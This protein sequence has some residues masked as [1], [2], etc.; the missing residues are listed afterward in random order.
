VELSFSKTVILAGDFELSEQFCSRLRKPGVYLP[1]IDAPCGRLFHFNKNCVFVGN[2][3]RAL[4]PK[5]L[6][7]LKVLPEVVAKIRELFPDLNPLVIEHFDENLL[8][9]HLD[10][11]RKQVSLE[12]LKQ[13]SASAFAGN[14]FAVEGESNI[15]SVIAANLAIAHGGQVL[16]IPEVSEDEIDSLKEEFRVWSNS[17]QTLEKDQCRDTVLGF[18]KNRLPA[19]FIFTRNSKI[20]AMGNDS[21]ECYKGL[22]MEF[23][24]TNKLEA[25]IKMRQIF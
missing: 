24:P 22:N 1:V 14:L 9:K 23:T 7:F 2:A 11:N 8:G 15:S 20:P 10:L 3:I 25:A 6:L 18:M 4:R 17:N 12:D 5:T 16:S 21:R 13:S 19:N